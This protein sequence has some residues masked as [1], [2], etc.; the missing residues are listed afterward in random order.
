MNVRERR[1]LQAKSEAAEL[2]GLWGESMIAQALGVHELT[3]RR[4]Y[5][6]EI[7]APTPVLIALRALVNC[8][9]PGQ[10]TKDWI[11]WRFGQHGELC[12]P[13]GD[14]HTPGDMMAQRYERQLIKHLQRENSR[15]QEK[16]QRLSNLLNTAANDPI[17][18]AI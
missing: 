3:V 15:L 10:N 16:V 4:W 18:K 6:G 11:G 8:Q 9:L 2:I 12:D 1:Q 7:V 14:P 13:S 17:V 5:R